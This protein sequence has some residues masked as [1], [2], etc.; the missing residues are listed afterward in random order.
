MSFGERVIQIIKRIPSGRVISYGQ[1]A[2]IAGTPRAAIIVGQI[3][4]NSA[5]Q[6]PWQRV[7]N[8]KGIISIVNMNFPAELQAEL[9]ESEGITVE[10]LDG[11]FKVDLQKYGWLP[12][13]KDGKILLVWCAGI[14]QW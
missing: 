9:L 5:E 10:K 3:L 4:R 13:E 1:V 12:G 8:S 2:A 11:H 6:L 7:I 14:A